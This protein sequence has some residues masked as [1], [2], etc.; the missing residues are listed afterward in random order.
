[1][2][3][4]GQGCLPHPINKVM[5][6]I[7][8]TAALTAG[9]HNGEHE[10][11]TTPLVHYTHSTLPTHHTSHTH[12][13]PEVHAPQRPAEGSTKVPQGQQA[14]SRRPRS[15]DT[16]TTTRRTRARPCEHKTDSK[17]CQDVSMSQHSDS[18]AAQRHDESPCALS[19]ARDQAGDGCSS[20][21]SR[22]GRRHN[23]LWQCSCRRPHLASGHKGITLAPC[24]VSCMPCSWTSSTSKL[25]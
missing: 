20:R 22:R 11:S 25:R 18:T 5:E 19:Q 4:L 15:P 21:A 14:G 10:E 17:Q 24:A 16:R 12:Y 1:L 3:V 6:D 9:S 2:G 23:L 13:I 8:V 7:N